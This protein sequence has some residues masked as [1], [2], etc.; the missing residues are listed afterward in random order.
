MSKKREFPPGLGREYTQQVWAFNARKGSVRFA[1]QALQSTADCPMATAQAR[2]L[3][4]RTAEDCTYLL[5]LLGTREDKKWNEI[6][7][8]WAEKQEEEKNGQEG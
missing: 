1:R 5:Q 7:M 6:R 3:A 2:A 8:K 4:Q